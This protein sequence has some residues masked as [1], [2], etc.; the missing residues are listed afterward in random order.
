MRLRETAVTDTAGLGR[1]VKRDTGEARDRDVRVL[2]PGFGYLPYRIAAPQV[3]IFRG[4]I[5][6]FGVAFRRHL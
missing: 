3:H 2:G 1:G 4:I 5:E 6:F